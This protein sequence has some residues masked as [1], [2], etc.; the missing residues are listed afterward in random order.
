MT[1]KWEDLPLVEGSAELDAT[2]KGA[3]WLKG[4]WDLPMPGTPEY[5]VLKKVNEGKP[6]RPSW[7]ELVDGQNWKPNG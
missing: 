3:D 2:D 7:P 1:S 4:T 5:E 6:L